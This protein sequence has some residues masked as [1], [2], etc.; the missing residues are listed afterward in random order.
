M[1][2]QAV[3]YEPGGRGA[4]SVRVVHAPLDALV[5]SGERDVVFV[6]LGGGRFAPREVQ[7]GEREGE[8][9]EVVRGLTEGEAVVTRANFLI[10]SESQ[11]RASLSAL[12][13][14]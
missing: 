14:N 2:A 12:G 11:L 4:I 6:A 8:L 13:G 5:R 3:D 7:L 9:V 10:D 1:R